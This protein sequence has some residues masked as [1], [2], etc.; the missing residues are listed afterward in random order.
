MIVCSLQSI[1]LSSISV[2]SWNAVNSMFPRIT[3]LLPLSHLGIRATQ[4]LIT[5]R[6]VWPRINADVHRWGRTWIQCQQSK[7]QCHI[8]APLTTFATPDACF[9]GVHIDLV[10]PLPS[11]NKYTY[12]LT[13]IDQFT[14][15]PEALPLTTIIAEAVART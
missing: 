11:S 9:D 7:I 4:C 3:N 14:H 8:T 2:T 10:G 5:S 12:I 15:W 1:C 6:Y 13:C